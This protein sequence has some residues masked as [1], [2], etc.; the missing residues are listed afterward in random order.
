MRKTLE[1][2]A[3]IVVLGV[4]GYIGGK[5]IEKNILITKKAVLFSQMQTIRKYTEINKIESG[6]W[7]SVALIMQGM[8][9]S[10]CKSTEKPNKYCAK[11]KRVKGNGRKKYWAISTEN[12]T[13]YYNGNTGEAYATTI[14]KGKADIIAK[15]TMNRSNGVLS[16]QDMR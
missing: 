6:R 11:I 4:V 15:L 2:V 7:P 1:I 16:I 14:F 10:I 5:A 3:V 8:G 13:I 9:L 12:G